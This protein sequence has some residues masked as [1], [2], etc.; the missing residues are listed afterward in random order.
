M[1]VVANLTWSTQ[2]D[3]NTQSREVG[4]TRRANVPRA[5]NFAATPRIAESD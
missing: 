1:Q 2:V 5:L 4:P 3:Q